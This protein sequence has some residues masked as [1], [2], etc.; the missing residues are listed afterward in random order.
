MRSTN[1]TAG[2]IIVSSGYCSCVAGENLARWNST[3][4]MLLLTS[5][6]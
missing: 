3:E 6:S 4:L 5:W 2:Y 1:F